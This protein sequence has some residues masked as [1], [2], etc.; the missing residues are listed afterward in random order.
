M[1]FES[2][3]MQVRGCLLRLLHENYILKENMLLKN[4]KILK[5]YCH[6][7]ARTCN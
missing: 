4:A 7:E 2:P 5:K 1:A 6:V 3:L